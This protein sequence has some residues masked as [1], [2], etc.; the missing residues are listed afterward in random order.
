[1]EYE[2]KIVKSL[3]KKYYKRKSNHKDLLI[4]RRI[5]LNVKKILKN[6]DDYNVD[7]SEKELV[8]KAINNLEKQHFI[9]TTKLKYSN[10]YEKIYL[11]EDNVN[12]LENHAKDKLAITPRSFIVDDLNNLLKEYKGNIVDYYK[13]DLK[14]RM[15]N[16][17]IELDYLKEED[18]L[19]TLSFLEN[20]HSFMYLREASILIFKDS[21]YF[22]KNRKNQ[23][24]TILAKY[25]NSI[26]EEVYEDENL[27][28]RFNVYDSDQDICIK[29]K[30]II[31]FNHKQLDIEG[32][33]GGVAFSIKDIEKIDKIIVKNNRVM[34]I[35]NKT[36]F[37][38]MNQDDCYIYLGGFANKPQITFIKKLIDDNK[39]KEYLHFGDIDAGGF[40]IVKN[41]CKQTNK[42]FKLFHMSKLDLENNKPYLKDLTE[43]DIKRLKALKEDEEYKECISYMLDNNVKLEQEIISL[44]IYNRDKKEGIV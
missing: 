26:G 15:L 1:M 40:W 22:E 18:I 6:Y 17:S 14:D 23:V 12:E 32:L 9:T 33:N 3:L 39:D 36:S 44:S 41:L 10:D 38:R 8:D 35:E 7:I 21:K 30:V 11:V 37:L 13:E 42:H 43:S 4:K 34:T 16:S 27:L 29:G 24:C 31:C 25:F 2:S 28:T 5:D 20:N 19:K